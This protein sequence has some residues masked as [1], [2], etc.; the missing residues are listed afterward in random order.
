[1]AWG[2]C[3]ALPVEQ[4]KGYQVVL[5]VPDFLYL[6]FPAEVNLGQRG[7]YWGMRAVD[8]WRAFAWAPG[9]LPMNAELHPD[10]DGWALSTVAGAPVGPNHG[11]SAAVFGEMLRTDGQF[12]AQVFPRLLAVAERA[13]HTPGWELPY[14][15]GMD[16]EAGRTAR[17][18]LA[19][20]RADIASHLA[21]VAQREIARLGA[22]GID[23]QVSPP[24]AVLVDG[25]LHMR[26]WF[27]LPCQYSRDGGQTWQTATS[28]VPVS[29]ES[30]L[31]RCT[32]HDGRRVSDA[33]KVPAQ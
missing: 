22:M 11:I 28:A 33:E 19:A 12:V 31:V 6:D 23:Y 26:S 21:V 9:N 16:F 5:T 29:E 32:S 4:A 20:V 24:G 8:Y 18:D 1:M 17:V 2:V 13:W 15:V 14:E 27:G 30:V 25:M 10:R 7:Y 3:T